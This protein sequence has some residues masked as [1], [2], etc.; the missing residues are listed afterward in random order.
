MVSVVF[1]TQGGFDELRRS[2]QARG[3]DDLAL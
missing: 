1:Q 3:Q 2:A